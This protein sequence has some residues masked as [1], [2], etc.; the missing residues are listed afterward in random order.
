[1]LFVMVV[2]GTR[3][4]QKHTTLGVRGLKHRN[5]LSQALRATIPTHLQFDA[6]IRI[7]RWKDL[8]DISAI[9]AAS[10]VRE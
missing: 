10:G 3:I 4:H 5:S 9:K 7:R 1:M 8:P 2:Y 6:G